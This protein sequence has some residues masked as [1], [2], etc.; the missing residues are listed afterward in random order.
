[1]SCVHYLHPGT[2]APTGKVMLS[3]KLIFIFM[4]D[5]SG[6]FLTSWRKVCGQGATGSLCEWF[7]WRPK[8][9]GRGLEER[10]G[11]LLWRESS[12]R[13]SLTNTGACFFQISDGCYAE[14]AYF[15]TRLLAA[16]DSGR[17]WKMTFN[18][19]LRVL[20]PCEASTCVHALHGYIH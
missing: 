3:L 15:L 9:S 4:R 6:E 14:K 7:T 19:G 8:N 2:F 11:A 12:T 16:I 20:Q 17:P 5:C 10:N 18:K 1:M 13:C